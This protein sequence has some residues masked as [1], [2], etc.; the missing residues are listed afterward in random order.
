MIFGFGPAM[1]VEREWAMSAA[2]SAASVVLWLVALSVPLGGVIADRTG[3]RT[4][5][6]IFGLLSF[7]AILAGAVHIEAILPTFVALGLVAGLA[8]GPIMSLPSQVLTPEIRASG[9]GIFFTLFYICIFLAPILAGQLADAYGS[10]DVTF[11]FGA[12]MLVTSVAGVLIFR[13]FALE[14]TVRSPQGGTK[15]P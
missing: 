14:P 8:A 3:R 5:V 6:L 2:S 13:A 10:V 9:M 11:S 7:A 1:L 15:G 12:A 4:T